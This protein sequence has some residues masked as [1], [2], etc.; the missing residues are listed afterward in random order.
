MSSCNYCN[1]ILTQNNIGEKLL[2]EI[3]DED[4]VDPD[5]INQMKKEILVYNE[6]KEQ[7]NNELVEIEKNVDRTKSEIDIIKEEETFNDVDVDM[8]EENK[9]SMAIF[10]QNF[11]NWRKGYLEF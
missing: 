4:S 5:K 1:S 2:H 10:M 3:V 8:N 9:E 7:L 11:I 6:E